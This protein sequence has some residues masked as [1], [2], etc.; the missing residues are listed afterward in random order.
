LF[1]ICRAL[2]HGH[3]TFAISAVFN[4]TPLSGCWCD[5][6][7][8]FASHVVECVR[9]PIFSLSVNPFTCYFGWRGN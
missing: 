4:T 6:Y 1:F 7:F 3:R 2:V 8:V 5:S 9:P